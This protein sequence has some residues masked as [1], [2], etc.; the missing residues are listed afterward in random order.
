MKVKHV[1]PILSQR[2][3]FLKTRGISYCR[4]ITP[5]WTIMVEFF[6]TEKGMTVGLIKASRFAL[7]RMAKLDLMLNILGKLSAW[8]S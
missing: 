3:T 8:K 6:Y 5:N 7:E 4:K 2:I 1:S